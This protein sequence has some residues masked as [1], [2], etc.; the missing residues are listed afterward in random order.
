MIWDDDA[1]VK[2]RHVAKGKACSQIFDEER[3]S[4]PEVET[5]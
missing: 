1:L 5:G 4:V 2:S 3:V